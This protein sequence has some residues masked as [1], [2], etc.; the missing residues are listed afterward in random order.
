[1][2]L[3]SF[4][5]F[6]F[7][8]FLFPVQNLFSQDLVISEFLAIN[9]SGIKDSDGDYSDWIELYNPSSININLNGWF[10]TDSYKDLMKWRFPEIEIKPGEYMLIFASGKDYRNPK[11]ELHTNFRLSGGGEYLALVK[12]DGKTKVSNFENHYSVQNSDISFG[13]IE[14]LPTSFKSPTPGEVNQL[15]GY[16]PPPVFSVEHGFFEEP[17]SVSLSTPVPDADIY[18]TTDGST[19]DGYVGTKYSTPVQIN[20]TTP[21]RAVVVKNGMQNSTVVTQT[22][23][24]PDAVIGQT[25]N[26]DG[27]PDEWGPYAQKKGNATADYEMDLEITQNPLYKDLLKPG[28]L[29]IPTVSIVTDIDHLFSHSTDTTKGGIYIYTGAPVKNTI[30]RGWERPASIEFFAPDLEKDF[31][32]NIGLKLH[33]GHSRLP[34]KSPKH[35][36]RITFKS[37]YGPTKLHFPIFENNKATTRFNSIVLRAGFNKTWHHHSEGQRKSATMI[38]DPWAKDIQRTMGHNAGFNRF[39]HLYLNGLYWGVYNLAE[40]MDKEYMETYIGGNEEDF[41]VIKDYAEVASGTSD[42]WDQMMA[43]ANLGLENNNAY[44]LVQGNDKDGTPNPE[45]E[46]LLD[47]VNLIDYMILNI[48]AANADWDHHNWAATRNRINPGKG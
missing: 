21:I 23:I 20:T 26:P 34:E 38:T 43:L 9:S 12:P 17:F 32:V 22:Y 27:Y 40:R 30:G 44:Q 28:L 6:T 4:K 29:S 24:F 39:V 13:Y 14:G 5:I 46:N 11:H 47:V 36:F 16:L 1:M 45:K 15:S 35:S 10:L 2:K 48:Y 41:D 3:N 33:G 31:Q 8:V 37:A 7:L 19:P 18:Y 25:N 42:A